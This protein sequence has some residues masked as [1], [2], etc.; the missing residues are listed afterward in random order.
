MARG[1]N[2]SHREE[3][4]AEEYATIQRKVTPPQIDKSLISWGLKVLIPAK[5]IGGASDLTQKMLHGNL[6]KCAD[7]SETPHYLSLFP[8]DTEKPDFHRPE[9]FQKLF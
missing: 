1:Q 4:S 7:K 3:I 5:L 2:R 8:I 9:F 6:Y